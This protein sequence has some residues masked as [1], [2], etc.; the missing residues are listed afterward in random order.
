MS[1]NLQH[2]H[3]GDIYASAQ[4]KTTVDV[5]DYQYAAQVVVIRNERGTKVVMHHDETTGAVQLMAHPRDGVTYELFLGPH[6][7]IDVLASMM[8][9]L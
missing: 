6:V 1:L 3:A 4:H 7:P 9:H 5:L 2:S 8:E